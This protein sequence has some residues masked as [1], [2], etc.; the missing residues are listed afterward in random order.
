MDKQPIPTFDEWFAAKH[1]GMSFDQVHHADSIHGAM[2]ALS[3]YMRDYISE[4]AR[5]G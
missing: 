3:R 2:V 5:H 1:H 4:V